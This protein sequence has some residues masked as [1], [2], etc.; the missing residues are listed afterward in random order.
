VVEV[1]RQN[2]REEEAMAQFLDSNIEQVTR[3]ISPKRGVV[4]RA[5][6]A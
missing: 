6:P 4:T 2:L 3:T 5:S 1:C